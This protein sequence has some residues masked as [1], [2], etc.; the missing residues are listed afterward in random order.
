ME[1]FRK[2]IGYIL[3]I[4]LLVIL[5]IFNWYYRIDYKRIYTDKNQTFL[6]KE[7]KLKKFGFKDLDSYEAFY[8]QNVTYIE[9]RTMIPFVWETKILNSTP[10]TLYTKQL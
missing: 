3:S 6:N 2:K 1:Q 4:L 7:E 8:E 9:T 5:I 10:V